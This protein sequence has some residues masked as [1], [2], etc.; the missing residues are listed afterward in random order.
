MPKG[1]YTHSTYHPIE[2][3]NSKVGK[4]KR[5]NYILKKYGDHTEASILLIGNLTDEKLIIYSVTPDIIGRG[6]SE[7]VA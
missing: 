3:D 7:Y 1:E 5:G 2:F 4:N 6:K